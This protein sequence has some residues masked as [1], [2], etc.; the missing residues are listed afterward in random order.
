MPRF[1]SRSRRRKRTFPGDTPSIIPRPLRVAA[2]LVLVSLPMGAA[3]QDV[4]DAVERDYLRT[5]LGIGS[6]MASGL[7]I[8]IY[9]GE[10]NDYDWPLTWGRV[11]ERF[12]TTNHFRFDDNEFA[13][14]NVAHP[15]AGAMYYG[16]ARSN[17]F[18]P[19]G[20]ALFS[21][22]GSTFWEVVVELRE[23]ASLNDLVATPSTGIALGE[24]L[25]QH[26][27]FFRRSRPGFGNSL[28]RG[29]LGAPLVMN[30]MFGGSASRSREDLDAHGFPADR[31][32]RFRIYAGPLYR[33]R[34]AE[35]RT[36]AAQD[37]GASAWMTALGGSSEISSVDPGDAGG[38][39]ETGG[40]PVTRLELHTAFVGTRPTELHLGAET[41][42]G[43]WR[44]GALRAGD[45]GEVRGHRW[46]L[47]P[48]TGFTMR[49]DHVPDTDYMALLGAAHLIGLRGD[50]VVRYGGLRARWNAGAFADFSSIRPLG[51]QWEQTSG[52]SIPRSNSVLRR[53]LYYYAW[54]GTLRSALAV[55]AGPVEI[56]GEIQHHALRAIEARHRR[57]VEP[58]AGDPGVRDD[59]TYAR[60]LLKVRPRDGLVVAAGADGWEGRGTIGDV[61]VDAREARL[62][63]RVT[64]TP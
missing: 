13:M 44:G 61:T 31:T 36:G 27:D 23:V 21:A 11:S 41:V 56:R 7:G 47:G 52:L 30:R 60:A 42:F 59:R 2:L 63:F 48:A 43:G 33:L 58:S 22:G 15:V 4:P 20:S 5:S 35:L 17:G 8:Y 54:G 28:V 53:N 29:L 39:H 6:I 25:Y 49:L 18:G 64:A 40:L 37:R 14:N 12:T 62:L 50:W 10:R 32:H 19:L 45:D 1:P 24:A 26:Q 55:G 3:A 51:L 46:I 38:P 16:L 34:S 57:G 9:K